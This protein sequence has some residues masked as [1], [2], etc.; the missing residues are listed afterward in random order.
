MKKCETKKVLDIVCCY[1][2]CSQNIRN[3]FLLLMLLDYARSEIIE[4]I[5]S[6]LS[7]YLLLLYNK[8]DNNSAAGGFKDSLTELSDNNPSNL[9]FNAFESALQFRYVR[10]L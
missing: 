9:Y 7:W 10:D 2:D 5:K 3:D 6:Y 1:K 4:S 8:A